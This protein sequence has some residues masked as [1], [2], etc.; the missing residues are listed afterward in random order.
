M[1]Y[2]IKTSAFPSCRTSEKAQN[3]STPL[4]FKASKDVQKPFVLMFFPLFGAHLSS[5]KIQYP[6][7]IWQD[8]CGKMHILW[9]NVRDISSNCSIL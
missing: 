9:P 8:L 4:L 1:R 7:L 2:S 6:G 5:A 3:A